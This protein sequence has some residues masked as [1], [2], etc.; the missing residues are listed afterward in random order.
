MIKQFFLFLL[1][2]SCALSLVSCGGE[3]TV[4]EPTIY[5]KLASIHKNTKSPSSSSVSQFRT[6]IDSMDQY[7]PETVEQLA[8]SVVVAHNTLKESGLSVTLLEFTDGME[9]VVRETKPNV[10]CIEIAAV[11]TTSMTAQ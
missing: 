11:L 4:G 6:E 1:T 9:D 2:G 8:N 7:C 3:S 10:P 5:E